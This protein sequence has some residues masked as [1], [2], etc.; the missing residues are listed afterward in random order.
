MP[1][2]RGK[3][4]IENIDKVRDIFSFG[5]IP[6]NLYEKEI[7]KINNSNLEHIKFRL[8]HLKK[9]YKEKE[10]FPNMTIRYKSISKDWK[11]SLLSH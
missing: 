6:F 2:K 8:N 3:K 11:K 1:Q 9:I 4:S 5:C 7:G 10:I